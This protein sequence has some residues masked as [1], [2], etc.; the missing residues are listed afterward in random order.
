MRAGTQDT[1]SG[2]T[3][4]VKLLAD[5]NSGYLIGAHLLGTHASILIQPLIQAMS[6]EQDVSTLARG[7]YWIHPAL[8]EVIEKALLDLC[9]SMD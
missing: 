3:G 5:R 8:T 2:A 9:H 6:F 4:L 7:Q 1:S